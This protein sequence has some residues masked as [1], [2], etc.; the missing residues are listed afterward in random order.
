[1]LMNMEYNV[2]ICDKLRIER[3]CKNHL[4]PGA[5]TNNF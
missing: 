1:M 4:K 3:S 2:N 5:H